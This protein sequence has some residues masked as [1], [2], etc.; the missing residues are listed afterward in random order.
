MNTPTGDR[1]AD[2]APLDLD[3]MAA[4]MR[5]QRQTSRR[6]EA[7]LVSLMLVNWGIVW[8][9]GFLVLW[10]GQVGGNPWFTIPSP[11]EAISF[12]TL[13]IIGVLVSIVMGTRMGRGVRGGTALSN[14]MYGGAWMIA[15]GGATCLLTALIGH[16]VVPEFIGLVAPALFVF[17]AGVV[18]LVGAA[19][20]RSWPAFGLGTSIIAITVAATF[21]GVPHHSLVY[22]IGSAIALPV[23]AWLSWRD[24]MRDR[25]A[26]PAEAEA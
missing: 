16:G 8:C 20:W 12:A 7:R 10:S 19:I 9:L 18:Y 17:T 4:L 22:A 24:M 6:G 25:P 15:M 11:F 1:N 14:S 2:E 23:F 5:A 26:D 3:D 21:V 13:M